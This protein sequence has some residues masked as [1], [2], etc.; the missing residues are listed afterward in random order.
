V[1]E[2]SIADGVQGSDPSSPTQRVSMKSQADTG[3][4]PWQIA[5]TSVGPVALLIRKDVSENQIAEQQAVLNVPLAGLLH[6]CL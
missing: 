6:R 4:D 2:N 3:A 5:P 1:L